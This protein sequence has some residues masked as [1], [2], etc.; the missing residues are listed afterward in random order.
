MP[1]LDIVGGLGLPRPRQPQLVGVSNVTDLNPFPGL[2]PL[3]LATPDEEA[4]TPSIHPRQE[5]L[6]EF[7]RPYWLQGEDGIPHAVRVLIH[8]HGM[9]YSPAPL[10]VPWLGCCCSAGTS[11]CTY[12]PGSLT[13]TAL[14]MTLAA[15]WRT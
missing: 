10:T 11:P 7:M 14:V 4:Y 5:W 12:V 8:D 9:D 15:S 13:A 1:L 6:L 2:R 3:L